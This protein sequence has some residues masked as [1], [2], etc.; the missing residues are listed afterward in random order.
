MAPGTADTYKW[1]CDQAPQAVAL[2]YLLNI[3]R[4]I[5]LLMRLRTVSDSALAA[6]AGV[7]IP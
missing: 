6:K 7:T 2:R 1:D 5:L 3:T 4:T